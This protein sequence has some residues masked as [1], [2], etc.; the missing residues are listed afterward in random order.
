MDKHLPPSYRLSPAA[1]RL[2]MLR[3]R[4]DTLAHTD[5]RY[6]QL[7]AD[8]L[9]SCGVETVFDIHPRGCAVGVL[10]RQCGY[11]GRII[12]FEPTSTAWDQLRYCSMTDELWQLSR[13]SIRRQEDVLLSDS[14][15]FPLVSTRLETAIEVFCDEAEILAIWLSQPTD[16]ILLEDIHPLPSVRVINLACSVAGESESAPTIER[17]LTVLRQGQWEILAVQSRPPVEGRQSIYADVL[18]VRMPLSGR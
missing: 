5:S 4:Q 17:A 15:A 14:D 18:A 16:W 1:R 8:V 2:R 6:A 7:V 3:V 11:R 9:H 13:S 12:T 10:L